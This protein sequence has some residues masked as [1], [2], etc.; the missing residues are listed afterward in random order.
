VKGLRDPRVWLGLAVTVL[1]LWLALRDVDYAEVGRAMAQ[2]NWVLLLAVSIPAHLASVWLR[3]LRW[4]HLT[5]PIQRIPTPALVR[6]TAVG[7]M[8][9]N[10]I[11]L[12]VGEVI[13]AWYLARETGASGSALFGTVVLERVIDSM[14][15]LGMIAAI[16]GIYGLRLGGEGLA[17]GIPLVALMAAPVAFVAALR[18]WPDMA[19]RLSVGMLRPFSAALAERV[20]RGV[21][22]FADGLG[23]I[24][25]GGHL[26]WIALHS[27]ALWLVLSVAPFWAGI[28]ALGIDLGSTSRT[29]AASYVTLTAVGLAVAIPSAPGFFGPYHL[30]CRAALSRFG[31]A[32]ATAVAMGTVTHAVFWVTVTA[33]GLAVLRLRRTSLE[34]LSAHTSLEELGDAS[35]PPPP[36]QR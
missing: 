14:V 36:P 15:F 34:D 7:F 4:R 19:V 29:L 11:P 17:V 12:R 28:S 5:D 16:V 13:R 24:S 26:V 25:R 3:A 27:V 1:C 31:V 6:A 20:E 32:D 9:N 22:S 21:R 18:F 2:A 8:A 35:P 33:L 23:A 30:A 10:L